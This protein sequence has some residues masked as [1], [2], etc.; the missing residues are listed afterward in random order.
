MRSTP[1][2]D[3]MKQRQLDLINQPKMHSQ[4]AKATSNWIQILSADHGGN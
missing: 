4:T 3:Q 2:T 1:E